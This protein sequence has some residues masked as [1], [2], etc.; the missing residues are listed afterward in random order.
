MQHECGPV[1]GVTQ[2]KSGILFRRAEKLFPGG[3][4]SPVR[5]YPPYPRFIASGKGTRIRDVDGREYTDYVLGFGPLILGHSDPGVARSVR[6]AVSGGMMFAAPAEN[7]LR[8]ALKIKGA[9]RGIDMMR[10]VS[11]GT[12]ATMHALRLCMFCTG[13]KKVLKIS[14]GYHGTHTLNFAGETVDEVPFNS[15]ARIRAKLLTREYAAVIVEP[16][17]G[18]A[19]LILPAPGYLPD[20]RD[21]CNASGTL[22]IC[23]EVITGFR[24]RFGPY[25]ESEGVVPDL[26]TFGKIVGGGMPLAVFG[27]RAELMDK[28]KPSGSFSQAGTYSAHPACVGAG[29]ATLEILERKDYGRLRRMTERAASLLAASGLTVKW[30]TGM[31][32]LF[33][34]ESDVRDYGNVQRIDHGLF[35][36]LFAKAL[37]A[38]VFIPA[39]QEETMFISFRHTARQ[40]SEH[41]AMLSEEATRIYR[42]KK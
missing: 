42:S 13:R 36:K 1:S 24:T 14:G 2:L 39:S 33:F 3:V 7:E 5:Y 27:G 40:V 23:D 29:L 41:F 25:C 10:F 21:Y 19:G 8:L 12:E 9:C 38:G 34:T 18:N 26:Y 17:M 22:M 28:L 30:H 4:N 16:I 15:S 31:V 11:S 37:D 35:L 32:S 6:S 20:I